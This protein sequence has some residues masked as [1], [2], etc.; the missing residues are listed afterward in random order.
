MVNLTPESI[1]AREAELRRI[2]Q[3]ATAELEEIPAVKRYMARLEA[4]AP[5]PD[6]PPPDPPPEAEESPQEADQPKP[7]GS[8]G[9]LTGLSRAIMNIL[10][11]AAD[12]WMTAKQ[13]Q[14]AASTLL[15]TEVPMS[16]ISPKLS[17]MKKSGVI[18]RDDMHVALTSRA[19]TID[20]LLG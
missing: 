10:S 5:K 20:D 17:D 1:L 11:T 6:E 3:E 19:N 13:I 12:P 9:R 2:I 14:T 18:R 16:S 8:R 7:A 15:G 4:N